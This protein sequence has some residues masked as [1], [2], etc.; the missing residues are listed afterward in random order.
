LTST[1]ASAAP[2]G[3]GLSGKGRQNPHLFAKEQAF[4]LRAVAKKAGHFCPEFRSETPL[5]L[6][7]RRKNFLDFAFDWQIPD[8]RGPLWAA[9]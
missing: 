3:A 7:K 5:A 2:H 6:Q 1:R 9:S 8:N 4:T